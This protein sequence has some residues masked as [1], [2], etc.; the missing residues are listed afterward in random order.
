MQ[1][2]C[3]GLSVAHEQG[4]VHRDIKPGNILFDN[5]GHA[6]LGDFGLARVIQLSST[7]AASSSGGV[8]TPAYR[9]PELWLGKP[10]ASPATDIYSLGCVLSEMLTGKALF[11]GDTTEEV[12][13]KHLING[14]SLPKAF[15]VGVPA[16]ILAVVEK[17][18]S[19]DTKERYQTVK[20]FEKRLSAISNKR[21]PIQK[22]EIEQTGSEYREYR[23]T[24]QTMKTDNNQLVSSFDKNLQKRKLAKLLLGVAGVIIVAFLIVLIVNKNNGS[25]VMTDL[26]ISTKTEVSIVPE[27]EYSATSNI[28]PVTNAPTEIII[29]TPAMASET[30]PPPNMTVEPTITIEPWDAEMYLENNLKCRLGPDADLYGENGLIGNEQVFIYGKNKQNSWFFIMNNSGKQCWVKKSSITTSPIPVISTIVDDPKITEP[31]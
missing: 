2:V 8:G 12:L 4:L 11:D 20:E 25:S 23:V 31:I 14:P 18:V 17:A 26:K 10:P 3:D 7:S 28:L 24:Y 1:Q 15:P 5:K 21:V 29:S 13:T 6:V 30:L 19:K 9:A 27:T 16:G 22:T